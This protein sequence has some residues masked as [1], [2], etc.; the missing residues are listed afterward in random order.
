MF[1]LQG[2]IFFYFNVFITCTFDSRVMSLI[3]RYLKVTFTCT[4]KNDC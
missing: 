1:T 3:A 4:F 2:V